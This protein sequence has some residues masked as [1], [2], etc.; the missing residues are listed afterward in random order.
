M[1]PA[2][3]GTWELHAVIHIGP[4]LCITFKSNKARDHNV[5][6]LS[7]GPMSTYYRNV[8]LSLPLKL[9]DRTL[10]FSNPK[11]EANAAVK[12][13]HLQHIQHDILGYIFGL[14]I[15]GYCQ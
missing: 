11:S 14:S 7:C 1:S 12:L 8:L 15:C 3:A 10:G 2:M 13:P 9:N 4:S 5:T 6:T